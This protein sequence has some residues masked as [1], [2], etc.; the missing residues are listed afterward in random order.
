MS[1][2]KTTK[3]F[4]QASHGRRSLR[5]CATASEGLSISQRSTPFNSSANRLSVGKP[6]G[7]GLEKDL[8]ESLH[9]LIYTPF[10]YGLLK[11]LLEPFIFQNR[12]C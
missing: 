3:E 1:R 9:F 6:L 11:K 10:V 12:Y 5:P 8:L 7:V 4:Y 2:K